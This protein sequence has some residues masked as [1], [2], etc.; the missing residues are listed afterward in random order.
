MHCELEEFLVVLAAIP[1]FLLHHLAELRKLVRILVLR[2]AGVE[3][4]ALS[5]REFDDFRSERSRKRTH[6]AE[7]HTPGILVYAAETRL[8]LAESEQVHKCG[9]LHVLAERGY[10]WRVAQTRPNV[11]NFVE[12]LDHKRVK[13]ALRLAVGALG[14]VDCRLEALE[15]CHH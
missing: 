4:L 15:V 8:V 7:Y 13:I 5:L 6:L 12:E 10:E 3:F 14:G 1:T 2:V 9:V 11:L